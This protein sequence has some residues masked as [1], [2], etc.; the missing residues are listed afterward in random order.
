MALLPPQRRSVVWSERG[1]SLY[2]LD[3]VSYRDY[4]Y[5]L[6]T[7]SNTMSVEIWTD[8]RRTVHDT[9]RRMIEE[10]NDWYGVPRLH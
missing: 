9:I 2:I 8:Q 5:D 4:L 6:T 10:L 7:E 3:A 1:R